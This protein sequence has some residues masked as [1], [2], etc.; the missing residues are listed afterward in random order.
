M[1]PHNSQSTR[2]HTGL[3]LFET[4]SLVGRGLVLV[5]IL[6]LT[7]AVSSGCRTKPLLSPDHSRSQFDNYDRIR[8]QFAPQY[9]FDE[10][11]KRRPN[12]SGR[13]LPRE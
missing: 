10:Y 12:L 7:L 5:C 9:V 4:P 13:L 6:G 2:D 1:K 3:M 8:D 11:G